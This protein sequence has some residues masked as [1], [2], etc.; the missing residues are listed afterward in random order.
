MAIVFGVKGEK[1]SAERGSRLVG[2]LTFYYFFFSCYK[3]LF[4][5]LQ[6]V[7]EFAFGRLR[8]HG[9]TTEQSGWPL[10]HVGR[11]CGEA[12]RQR[13]KPAFRGEAE[14][15]WQTCTEQVVALQGVPLS[16]S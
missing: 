14:G 5:S 3:I 12:T 13:E 4:F 11:D 9:S 6:L 10:A 8:R 15:T 2:F 1:R 7:P 16:L